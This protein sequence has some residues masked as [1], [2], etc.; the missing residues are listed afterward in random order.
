M[1]CLTKYYCVFDKLCFIYEHCKGFLNLSLAVF[2][3]FVYLS[4][5]IMVV[6]GI[7]PG[8]IGL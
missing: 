5:S 8:E 1:N 3:G 4:V 2:I 6:F 7:I